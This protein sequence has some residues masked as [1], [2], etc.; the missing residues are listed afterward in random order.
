MPHNENWQEL[1]N[2]IRKAETVDDILGNPSPKEQRAET[3]ETFSSTAIY[4]AVAQAVESLAY[5]SEG[6]R[7]KY[8]ELPPLDAEMQEDFKTLITLLE[9]AKKRIERNHKG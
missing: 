5:M 1:I 7:K 8:G 4:L 2:R 9:R 6:Y 3:G